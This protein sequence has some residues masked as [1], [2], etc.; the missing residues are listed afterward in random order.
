VSPLTA[1]RNLFRLA[2]GGYVTVA[3][4][5]GQRRVVL[6]QAM[7]GAVGLLL[8]VGL[9]LRGVPWGWQALGAAATG[10]A[11]PQIGPLAR[12]R[13]RPIATARAEQ[14]GDHRR[15]IDTAFSYEG[16]ADEASFVL[17][18]ALVGAGATLI[19]P[20][21]ALVFAAGLLAVSGHRGAFVVTVGAAA[22]AAVLVAASRRSLLRADRPRQDAPAPQ[23][24]T[25]SSA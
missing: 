19:N 21:A 18:P 2:G 8:V 12:V 20:A 16:A 15:L 1:Y 9:S 22:L 3:D 23:E 6:V 10:L 14:T 25:A 13:W 17:G 11:L 7:I 5:V 24:R 4:R